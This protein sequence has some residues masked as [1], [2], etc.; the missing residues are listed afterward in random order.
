MEKGSRKGKSV[1][2][3]VPRLSDGATPLYIAC[4]HG[5]VSCVRF[6]VVSTQATDPL[7]YGCLL[8]D[9]L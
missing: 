8:I 9:C 3:T 7:V 6:L 2:L 4:R 1:D 5:D